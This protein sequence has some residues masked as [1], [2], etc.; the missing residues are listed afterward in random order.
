[1]KVKY[2]AEIKDCR[3]CKLL[4]IGDNGLWECIWDYQD[5]KY[6]QKTCGKNIECK[7]IVLPCQI[8]PCPIEVKK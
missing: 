6:P 4:R 7:V 3:E 8:R 1:M 5:A 2:E